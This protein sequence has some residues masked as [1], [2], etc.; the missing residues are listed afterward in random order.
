MTAA[1]VRIQERA[2]PP[3]L[4]ARLARAVRGLGE[5]GLA[6]TY[7]TTFWFDHGAPAALPELGILALGPRLPRVG[8]TGVEWWLSRMRPTDVQVDFHQ[9]RDERLFQRTGATAHP[10][11]G[12]VLF[13]NRCRGGLLAVTDAPARD[14]NPAR[15]PDDLGAL[16]LVRP[17]PNRLVS[18]AGD[19]THGV[20][21]A[22]GEI[23]HR[24]LSPPAPL[25]LALVV[26][27][28]RRRPEGV[29]RFDEARR[30]P[31]LALAG[32]GPHSRGRRR[33][34]AGRRRAP[35]SGHARPSPQSP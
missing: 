19:A 8:I 31:S 1:L 28:W 22:N 18:F 4:F 14:G 21:D 34:G 25:R 23:P 33:A 11:F 17:W 29:P 16:D 15:A 6:Q 20:L 32:A 24:R 7:R 26:N 12:S 9:D 27:G 3:A 10:A 13:L 2:L 30:Y 5:E 35:G